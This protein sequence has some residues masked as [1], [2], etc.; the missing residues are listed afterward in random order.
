ML[1]QTQVSR[2]E[3]KYPEFLRQFPTLSALAR[4]PQRDVVMAWRGLGYNNRAVRLHALAKHLHGD[5]DGRFPRD[6]EA[7]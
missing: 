2:V 4:A 3:Q 6:V 5:N 1:Q 7:H